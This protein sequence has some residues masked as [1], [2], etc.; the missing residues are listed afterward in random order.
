MASRASVRALCSASSFC[1]VESLDVEVLDASVQGAGIGGGS[2][3]WWEA[4]VGLCLGAGGA[5]DRGVC[6]DRDGGGKVT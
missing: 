5:D 3:V 6:R 4:N 2:G 1:R